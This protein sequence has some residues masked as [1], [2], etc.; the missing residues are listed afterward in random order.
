MSEALSIL[1]SIAASNPT[2]IA[3]YAVELL[4][5]DLSPPSIVEDLNAYAQGL[6]S[7]RQTNTHEPDSVIYP[8]NLQPMHHIQ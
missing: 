6:E 8:Q 2:S 7:P 4:V 1:S 3:D 5:N